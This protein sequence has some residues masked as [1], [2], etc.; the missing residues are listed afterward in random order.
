MKVFFFNPSLQAKTLKLALPMMAAQLIWAIGPFANTFL[1]AKLDANSL[2]AI[3]LITTSFFTFCSMGWGILAPVGILAAR[4]HGANEPDKVA[5]V[6]QQGACLS[7]LLTPPVFLLMWHA[8]TILLFL[9]Q[10]PKIVALTVENF[11]LFAWMIPSMY[12]LS[13]ITEFLVGIGKTQVILFLSI[14]EIPLNLFFK[15][16][17]IFGKFGFPKLGL[18]GIGWGVL[19][20]DWL[21]VFIYTYYAAFYKQHRIYTLWRWHLSKNWKHLFEMIHLGWP[22]AISFVMEIGFIAIVT[23]L[24]GRLGDDTLAAN[25]ISLQFLTFFSA[26]LFGLGQACTALISRS[27]GRKNPIL[28]RQYSISGI[29]ISLYLVIIICIIFI[30]FPKIIIAIDLNPNDPKNILITNM[31]TAFLK[32][33]ALFILFDS[34]RIIFSA[35][36]RAYKD[37]HYA[38]Y[39][40]LFGFWGTGL[41]TAYILAFSCH[42]GIYGLWGGLIIGGAIGGILLYLRFLTSPHKKTNR[43]LTS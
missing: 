5:Q 6:V 19:L 22:I 23:L 41:F 38:M 32:C 24:T 9:D 15:Y 16:V 8:P 3:A 29:L 21:L 36:L 27:L 25:Q 12:F 43:P 28:A 31:A 35:I 26:M 18:I 1:A 7:L 4:Y 37:T 40:T 20:L 11:H 13:M 14:I 42:L 30:F 33:A 17:L 34:A 10:D 2:A 39:V